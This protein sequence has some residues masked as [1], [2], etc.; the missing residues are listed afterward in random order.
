MRMFRARAGR[1]VGLTAVA[2]VLPLAIGNWLIFLPIARGP[3]RIDRHDPAYLCIHYG[4]F[5]FSYVLSNFAFCVMGQDV[6][7]AWRGTRRPTGQLLWEGVLNTARSVWFVAPMDWLSHILYHIQPWLPQ[8]LDF[9]L[10][11][12]Y[13]GWLLARRPILT[14][15]RHAG[16]LLRR[17]TMKAVIGFLPVAV[18]AVLANIFL[19][20][21][22]HSISRAL[23]FPFFLM[24]RTPIYGCWAIVFNT[25]T[26][27]W[28]S[29]LYER[30]FT[31]SSSQTVAAVFE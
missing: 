19:L 6:F 26:L 7:D 16:Y 31:D 29:M 15:A 8:P 28:Y 18:C 2:Y 25:W 12:F 13:P 27:A 17:H 3:V 24:W 10:A 23:P 20:S 4:Y 1:V 30:T 22:G 9:A 21:H 5:V 14:S 11:A